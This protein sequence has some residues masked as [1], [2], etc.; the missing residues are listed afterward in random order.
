MSLDLFQ[1][2]HDS[3]DSQ[4]VVAH[5]LKKETKDREREKRRGRKKRRRRKKK[6]R[7]RRASA[8]PGLT[9]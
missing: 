9:M 5:P 7:R 4:I 2:I 6:K 3:L 8:A 1:K